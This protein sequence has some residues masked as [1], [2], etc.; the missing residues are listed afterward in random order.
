MV[1]YYWLMGRLLD[2]FQEEPKATNPFEGSPHS[3]NTHVYFPLFGCPFQQANTSYIPNHFDKDSDPL[4]HVVV[5]LQP[6][7]SYPSRDS[8]QPSIHKGHVQRIFEVTYRT[9]R[10]SP[11]HSPD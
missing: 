2:G 7:Q 1:Y 9:C 8:D 11:S 10:D 6:V 4:H 5:M 3:R